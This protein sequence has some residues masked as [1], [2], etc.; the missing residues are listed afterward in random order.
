VSATNR[1]AEREPHD[2]YPTPRWAIRR[3]LEE[4][5]LPRGAWLEPCA[6]EG[7]IVREI[8]P[9]ADEI[10]AIEILPACREP[11]TEALVQ[12]GK[13]GVKKS[14]VKIDD[15]LVQKRPRRRF[16]VVITNP[17]FSLGF[18][19]AKKAVTEADF[20]V[21]LL[22][23][24]FLGSGDKS[25]RSEWLRRHP[26]DVYVLPNRP[27]FVAS[28]RCVSKNM[29]SP[30]H[31]LPPHTREIEKHVGSTCPWRTTLPIE[32]ERPKRCPW[33]DGKVSCSTTDATEY[34]WFVWLADKRAHL[35]QSEFGKIKILATTPASE[36][37]AHGK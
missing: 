35:E 7:A 13:S 4:V 3:L 31:V 30:L 5:A 26:P 1:G 37:E 21:L 28:L 23:L 8:A 2:S 15:Y 25:G 17:P 6:G 22:R 11:L 36:R 33:C 14:G 9:Y 12:A 32:A 29:L 20:V 24:N 27:A 10:C 34:A 19:I 16:N 18:E